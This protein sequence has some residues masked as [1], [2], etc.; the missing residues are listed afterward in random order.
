M[1]SMENNINFLS[2]QNLLTHQIN[3]FGKKES[4]GGKVPFFTISTL[5][6]LVQT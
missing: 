2:N 1:L 4:F 3:L 6:S 5:Q